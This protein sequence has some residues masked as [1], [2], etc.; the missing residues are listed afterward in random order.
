MLDG[1]RRFDYV[2]RGYLP[3]HLDH[4]SCVVWQVTEE[5]LKRV[6]ACAPE[7]WIG[8]AGRD[9]K[10]DTIRWDIETEGFSGRE[11][12]YLRFGRPDIFNAQAIVAMLDAME[13]A[14]FQVDLK[15]AWMDKE[16]KSWI[17][18]AFLW[19]QTRKGPAQTSVLFTGA[20]RAEVVALAFCSMFEA[21]KQ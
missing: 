21:A 20:T 18:E 11:Q 10:G 14:G 1:G 3:D 17:A 7:S 13:G 6:A 2:R 8:P 5:L 15:T 4:R 12:V 19:L 9:V 16:P